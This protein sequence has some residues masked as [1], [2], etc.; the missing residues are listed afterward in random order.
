[1]RL[2]PLFPLMLTLIAAGTSATTAVDVPERLELHYSIH[3]K[4]MRVA[5]MHRVLMPD[6][7]NRY[8][9]QSETGTVGMFALLRKD[10]VVEESTWML[11]DGVP[12]PL[13][14]NYQHSGG[15]KNRR[16]AVTF[17]WE[18]RRITNTIN[19]ESWRMPGSPDVMDKLLYQLA[20]MF[21]LRAGRRPPF[22]YTVADG[23]KIKTYNF[24]TLGEETVHSELGD[25]HALVLKRSKP[26]SKSQTI[27]WCAPAL[28][29]LPVKVESIDED[30]SR[31]TALLEV[32]S[33]IK[34]VESE[35]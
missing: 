11:A 15:K 7:D 35:K 27:L 18:Q 17:D 4:G 12:R 30:G 29:Y 28:G 21:D 22:A 14:Y 33:G 31:T 23:G 3:S 8:R 24:E 16:V 20:V 13:S 5:E 2:R 34:A 25:M 1:M 6:G 9:F 10:R 19:G 32:M 26:D